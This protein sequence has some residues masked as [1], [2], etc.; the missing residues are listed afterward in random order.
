MLFFVFSIFLIVFYSCSEHSDYV[1]PLKAKWEKAIPYQNPPHG[2]SSISAESCGSC[3]QN[4]Y[5][6]WKRSTHRFAWLD[7]QFQ[8]EIKKD[9]SPFLCL[10]CH[11][12]LQ[13][14]Q[15]ELVHGLIN[16]NIYTP[17]TTKNLNYDKSLQLEGIT[18]AV[19]HVR[20]EQI[21]G[22]TGTKK[23][24]HS[25]KKDSEFLSERLC[26]SCHNASAIITEEL[27]CSF[28]TGDEWV[29]YSKVNGKTCIDCHMVVTNREIVT[30]YS[31]RE[32]RFHTFSGSG[33]PKTS[34]HEPQALNGLSI[35]MNPSKNRLRTSELY[36]AELTLRNEYAGHKVPTGDPERFIE[37][38]CE[39]QDENHKIIGSKRDTIGEK[40]KWYPNAQKLNENNL[41]PLQQHVTTFD[42]VF[43]DPGVYKLTFT[44]L[45]HRLD[46][47]SAHYNKLDESY[48][49]FIE[50][51][52]ESSSI[53]VK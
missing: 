22:P 29:A 25:T 12:P 23:A 31:T 33:I 26:I 30:G 4:H 20:D 6:E 47:K 27:V 46:K 3:H 5:N 13:N 37:I 14:Q 34:T 40:W 17:K 16:D 18:C 32:S 45:K 43:K 50:I 51:Y 1:S 21:I 19:C 49:L 24:P 10:N 52:N 7:Q 39:L 41:K 9:N 28:E 44:V 15:E 38:I 53:E 48:P 35:K 36:R 8:A 2:L 11:I 42:Y